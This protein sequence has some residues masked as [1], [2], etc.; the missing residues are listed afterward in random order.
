MA[1]QDDF[2][3]A[4]EAGD[5]RRLRRMWSS[6]CPHLPQPRTAEQAE[7]V[8]HHARTQAENISFKARAWSHRW[9]TERELPSGL[10]DQL[11]PQAERVY[12]RVVEAV[13]ISVNI[14]NPLLKPVGAAVQRA[15]GD[16]VEEAYADRRTDPVFVKARMQ[17]A[18]ERTFKAL[19]G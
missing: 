8:M 6:F 13:G 10:P 12:P 2:R 18:R 11:K 17:E 3:E 5:V 14:K 15:M 7:T 1:K 16:A 4:L 9:L 19:L